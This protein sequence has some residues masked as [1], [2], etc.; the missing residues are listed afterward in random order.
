VNFVRVLQEVSRFLD[1]HRFQHGLIGA[2]ALHGYGLTRATNDLD[3]VVEAR[4][5]PELLGFLDSLG[6]ERLHV[7]AGYSNHLHALP[8]MGRIDVVYVDE[9]TARVLF[10]HARRVEV[11]P[12]VSSL[13]PSPEHLAAM[14]VLAMK[15]DPSRTFREMA[16]IQHLLEMP[17]IDEN[18]IRAHFERHG[19]RERFDEIKRAMGSPR[20]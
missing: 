4:A 18:Q 16:D 15:N 20:S 7:S 12:G 8:E 17:G 9:A 6:Y 19:L 3:F 1:Q 10:G 13:V 5:Q 14:K 11:L 2:L